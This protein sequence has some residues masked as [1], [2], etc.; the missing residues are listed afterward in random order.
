LCGGCA[1]ELEALFI[2]K[3]CFGTCSSFFFYIVTG[4]VGQEGGAPW[5]GFTKPGY[6]DLELGELM[7]P[8]LGMVMEC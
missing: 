4:R 8:H 1:G 3:P 7:P 6:K 5:D 2:W